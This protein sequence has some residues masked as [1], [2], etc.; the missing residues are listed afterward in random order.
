MTTK[1]I[2]PQ[3]IYFRLLGVD[4]NRVLVSRTSQQPNVTSHPVDKKN[5]DQF[6]ELIPVNNLGSDIYYLIKAKASKMFLHSR[7]KPNPRIG[8]NDDGDK[9]KNWFKLEFGTGKHAFHF[10][11]VSYATHTVI[12]SLPSRLENVPDHI[13]IDYQYYSFLFEDL[14]IVDV[15]YDL[16][17]AQPVPSPSFDVAFQKGNNP[18]KSATIKMTFK[19]TK[20]QTRST[21]F[22]YTDGFSIAAGT[23]FKTGIPFI[24]DSGL[25]LDTSNTKSFKWAESIV[26]ED[27]FDFSFEVTIPPEKCVKA[28]AKVTYTIVNVPYTVT[29]RSPSTNQTTTSQG[30]LK[31]IRKWIVSLETEDC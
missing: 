13:K 5:E 7:Y 10:R 15:S 8:H 28:V 24:A 19:D 4:S 30:I 14:D 18:S 1:Y 2:P 6:F 9:A 25:K 3:K 11:L 26:Q 31:G 20:K 27:M 12:S 17:S 29:L 23:A 22:E 21:T 16:G